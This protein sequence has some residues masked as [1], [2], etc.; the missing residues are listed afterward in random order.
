M[1]KLN[2]PS[3]S[4][5][6]ICMTH[7]YMKID[8]VSLLIREMSIKTVLTFHLTPVRIIIIKKTNKKFW[9]ILERG[10]LMHL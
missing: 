8:S 10:N 1:G 6:K 9:Q 7:N 5:I 4:I 2:E 3:V